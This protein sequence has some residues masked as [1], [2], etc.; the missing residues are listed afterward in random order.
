MNPCTVHQ[1]P[2]QKPSAPAWRLFAAVTTLCAGLAACGGG[3][4]TPAPPP[5]A[6]GPETGC[7]SPSTV[8]LISSSSATVGRNAE[9]A[10]AGCST[11]LVLDP[12]WT[13]TAGPAV[14]LMSARSQAISFTPPS[15]G[16]YS[17][18]LDYR[19]AAGQPVSQT[20]TVAAANAAS[21]PLT[22]IRGEPSVLSGGKA[23][24]RVWTQLASG[25]SISSVSWQQL[26]G[27]AATIDTKDVDRERLIF[28]APQTSGDIV[29]KFRAT[30]KL[31]TGKEDSSDFSL[32]VQGLPGAPANQLFRDYYTATRVY[33]YKANGPYA[34][35][36]AECVYTPALTY[37]SNTNLCTMQRLPLLGQLLL[38]LLQPGLQ[39][40]R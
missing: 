32:L 19:N 14:A 5:P 29:L 35:A 15:A 16:N 38:L 13:Q 28:T 23:S 4:P 9:A 17:F 25:E 3:G 20:V 31:N 22:L 21:A 24:L 27:A 39:S 11:A 34:Q 1:S 40:S 18:R 26:R 12:V 10:L 33:P 7:A 37:G 30:V 6:P 2:G 36:L 8:Q